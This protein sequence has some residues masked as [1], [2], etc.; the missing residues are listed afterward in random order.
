MSDTCQKMDCEVTSETWSLLSV[1]E[2]ANI[3]GG[4]EVCTVC[5][6]KKNFILTFQPTMTFVKLS[7]KILV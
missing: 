1:L 3:T 2:V 5:S 6:K 7:D 4:S